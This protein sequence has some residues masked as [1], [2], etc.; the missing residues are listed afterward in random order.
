MKPLFWTNKFHFSSAFVCVHV[1]SPENAHPL[2]RPTFLL[3]C[4]W[5]SCALCDKFTQKLEKWTQNRFLFLPMSPSPGEQTVLVWCRGGE[6]T[7][8]HESY[9]IQRVWLALRLAV[10]CT[11]NVVKIYVKYLCA[12]VMDPLNRKT[13]CFQ[14]RTIS[15]FLG[16]RVETYDAYF[17]LKYPPSLPHPNSWLPLCY[18]CSGW[19]GLRSAVAGKGLW[20]K[21]I[22]SQPVR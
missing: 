20:R 18:D 5:L 9:Y 6:W 8:M 13:Y 17:K 11:W 16:G 22:M 21:E 7:N 3:I 14:A 19:V 15:I 4:I 1:Q 2:Q 10:S 12:C